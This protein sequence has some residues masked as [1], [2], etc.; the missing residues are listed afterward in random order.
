MLGQCQELVHLNLSGNYIR[1]GGVGRLAGVLVQCTALA[2]L[3]LSYDGIGTG[4]AERLVE[5]LP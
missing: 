5:V 2:H 1:A 4:G 3:D